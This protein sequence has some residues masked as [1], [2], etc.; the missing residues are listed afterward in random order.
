MEEEIKELLQTLNH[1][2]SEY[3]HSASNS[4][5]EIQ[6]E[7]FAGKADGIDDAIEEIYYLL[8]KENNG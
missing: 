7:Y 1:K 3:A 8:K 6:R 4:T 5:D 2:R